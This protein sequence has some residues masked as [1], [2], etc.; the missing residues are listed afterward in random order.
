M[1]VVYFIRPIFWP[2]M[3]PVMSLVAMI[4]CSCGTT[5]PYTY[6]QGSFDTAKLSQVPPSNPI[7]QKGDLLRIIVYSDNPKATAIYNQELITAQS[8]SSASGGA[9]EAA[10][11]TVS[12]A[13]PTTP[14]Y[15]VDDQGNI[16]FQ[17]LGLLHVEGLT[18]SQLK[19]TL[20]MRLKDYLTNPYYTIRFLNYRFTILGE[21]GHQGVYSIPGD[22]INLLQAL[23]MAGDMTFYGRRDNVLVIRETNGKREYGR[24][25]VTKPESMNSPFFYLQQND[26][27]Y[28]DQSKKKVAA[29][30]QITTRNIS[31]V[32]SIVTTLALLYS[33]LRK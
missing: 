25:D 27:V 32:T 11:Q 20:N 3:L 23:G 1:K 9:S 4:F 21:V 10:A 6:L 30:D 8:G 7:V 12:G 28:V 33:I 15:L 2:R 31:I 26:V 19:D 18:R 14:G 17:G 24:L 22:R 5:R 29:N 13:A 16:E